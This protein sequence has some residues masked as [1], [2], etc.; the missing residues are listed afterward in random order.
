MLLYIFTPA[1]VIILLLP[2]VVFGAEVQCAKRNGKRQYNSEASILFGKLNIQ[3][4]KSH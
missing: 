3:S 4:R 2:P 1:Q